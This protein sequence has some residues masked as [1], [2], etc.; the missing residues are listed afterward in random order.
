MGGKVSPKES[1]GRG[2]KVESMIDGF[3]VT[4]L[5]LESRA[6]IVLRAGLDPT[7]PPASTKPSSLLIKS[8]YE[9]PASLV[10]LLGG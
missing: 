8:S 10:P 5:L 3:W 7:T 9:G 6:S 1:D 2:S 4:G